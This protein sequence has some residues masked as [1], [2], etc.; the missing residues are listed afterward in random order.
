VEGEHIEGQG[1]LH[2]LRRRWKWVVLG[3]LAGLALALGLTALLPKKYT[4]TVDVQLFSTDD[5]SVERASRMETQAALAQSVPVAERALEKLNSSVDAETLLQNYSASPRTDDLLRFDASGRTPE[6]AAARVTAVAEAYLDFIGA[7][8]DQELDAVA[9]SVQS[10]TDELQAGISELDGQIAELN[11]TDSLTREDSFLLTSLIT[12]RQDTNQELAAVRANLDQASA[13][14]EL[15]RDR[16]KVLAA[17]LLPRAPTSPR[18]REF[19][20]IGLFGGALLAAGIVVAR[21]VLGRRLFSRQDF[22][23]AAGV[24]VV[25]SVDLRRRPAITAGRHRRRLAK[26]VASPSKSLATATKAMAA[27]LGGPRDLP[28]PIVVSSMAADDAAIALTLRLAMDLT[29]RSRGPARRI[30]SPEDGPTESPR[31]RRWRDVIV[32]DCTSTDEPALGSVVRAM[33]GPSG[34]A[35]QA[36]LETA[37]SF[38]VR[39]ISNDVRWDA[40]YPDTPALSVFNGMAA[41]LTERLADG[42]RSESTDKADL[43]IAYV[44]DWRAV[45]EGAAMPT[46]Q[47][48]VSFVVAHTGRITG[49]NIQENGAALHR[50]GAGPIGVVV[51]N[52]DRFDT[53]TG[54]LDSPPIEEPVAPLEPRRPGP[55]SELRA[56][57]RI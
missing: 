51:V 6:L 38:R 43:V 57:R 26:V 32:V 13:T 18:P 19:A 49:A 36:G 46:V 39:R 2:A 5:G 50:S 14:R 52:P 35:N 22:A 41:R 25:G 28:P 37:R 42:T 15:S 23:R 27:M 56:V 24:S 16:N 12:Q 29:S 48:G 53:S 21:D 55:D 30:D 34:E 44:G 9:R 54:Q 3:G 47:S 40:V 4:A 33:V 31:R 1:V 10:R 20:V 11:A 8:A 7:E 45:T 17:P